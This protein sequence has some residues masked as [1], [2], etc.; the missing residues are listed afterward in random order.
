MSSKERERV[1]TKY[2]ADD[3]DLGESRHEAGIMFSSDGVPLLTYAMFAEGLGDPGNYGATHPAVQ[4]H[5]KIGRTMLDNL[6]AVPA[7]V[8]AR[9]AVPRSLPKPFRPVNGG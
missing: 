2:G 7:G 5:A 8:S 3:N 6:P 1:A 9:A 4:A